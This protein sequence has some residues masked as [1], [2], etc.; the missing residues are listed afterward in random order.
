MSLWCAPNS[1]HPFP[2]PL[3]CHCLLSLTLFPLPP[4]EPVD[5]CEEIHF[6]EQN[7]WR[8]AFENWF[9]LH[10]MVDCTRRLVVGQQDILLRAPQLFLSNLGFTLGRELLL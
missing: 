1:P 4:F 8:S 3:C 9:A 7:S 2:L 6:R 10:F 5:C